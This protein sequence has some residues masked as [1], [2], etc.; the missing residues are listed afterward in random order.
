MRPGALL[1]TSPSCGASGTIGA[2]LMF[3]MEQIVL[4]RLNQLVSKGYAVEW[5]P[6]DYATLRLKHPDR[7]TVQ[8][9][10]YPDGRVELLRVP[11]DYFGVDEHGER[12]FRTFLHG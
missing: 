4:K 3:R 2:L 11:S 9:E 8:L 10:L 5:G 12:R 7:E 6:T 1:P